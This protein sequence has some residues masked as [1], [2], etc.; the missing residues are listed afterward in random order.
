MSRRRALARLPGV[1][2]VR[3]YR[4]DWLRSDLVAGLVLTALL[5]PAGMGYAEAAGLP[6]YAGL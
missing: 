5:I 6:A 2:T 4:R 3:G 1:E